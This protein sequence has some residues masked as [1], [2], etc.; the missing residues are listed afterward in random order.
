MYLSASKLI[1][2]VSA[3]AA[4]HIVDDEDDELTMNTTFLSLSLALDCVVLVVGGGLIIFD[5]TSSQS[6]NSV[7]C[8]VKQQ[9]KKIKLI[10]NSI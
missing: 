5:E 7:K 9:Q 3:A 1:G 6:M 2:D 4:R 10:Q 8:Q